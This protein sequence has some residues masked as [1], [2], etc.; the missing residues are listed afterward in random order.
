M[1]M[2]RAWRRELF[3][4]VATAAF[5]PGVLLLALIALAFAGSFGRLGLLGQ[6]VSG[7]A[8][9]AATSQTG[10][11]SASSHQLSPTLLAAL[12][13]A[14]ATPATGTAATRVAAAGQSPSSATTTPAGRSPA[15]ALRRVGPPA[16]GTARPAGS[17]PTPQPQPG[18][19]PAPHQTVIDRIVSAATSVTSQLP[20]PAGPLA[21]QALQS[22]GSTADRLLPPPPGPS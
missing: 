18:P 3:G 20:A 22:V 9:P 13:H 7:P 11:G 16:T 12:T 19:S 5:A 8:L 14:G 1:V 15:A 6:A 10:G 21:T 2:A 17:R 4:G